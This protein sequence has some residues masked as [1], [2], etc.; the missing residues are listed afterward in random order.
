MTETVKWNA[1]NFRTSGDFATFH[2]RTQDS[3]RLI[4]HLGAKKRADSDI[5]ASLTDPGNLLTWLGPDR[6]AVGF[7]TQEDIAAHQ[8]ELTAV[9]RQWI[10]F[11]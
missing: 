9:L 10:T 7:R 1:P 3:A 8:A 6:A 2:L 11:L 4:L 5:R